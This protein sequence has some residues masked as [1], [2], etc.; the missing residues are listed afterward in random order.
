M[1]DSDLLAPKAKIENTSVGSRPSVS[2]SVVSEEG[3]A[4]GGVACAY[5]ARTN[6]A[7]RSPRALATRATTF[8]TARGFF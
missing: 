1:Y 6:D 7:T 4:R 3:R 8:A 2:T 5:A